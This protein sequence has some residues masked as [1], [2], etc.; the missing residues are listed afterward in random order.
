MTEYTRDEIL[1]NRRKWIDFLKLP[2]TE[3]GK[4]VLEIYGTDQR[5]CLGHA[6][7]ILGEIKVV[8]GGVTLYNGK[9]YYAP[10]TI[11]EQL[12]L[13][14]RQGE[15]MGDE[16]VMPNGSRYTSLA[17]LNDGSDYTPQ[18]IG[19]YLESVIEGGIDTPFRPLSSYQ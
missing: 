11:V 10:E 17:R 1:A 3:K 18:D 6:C 16:I 13:Y 4:G 5:C 14:G 8:I 2:T 7:H 12:G 19:L 15:V 9:E